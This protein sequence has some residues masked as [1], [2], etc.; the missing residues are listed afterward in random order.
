MKCNTWAR[1][2]G[3]NLIFRRP[4]ASFW[5]VCGLPTNGDLVLLQASRPELPLSQI[6]RLSQRPRE[7]FVLCGW[8]RAMKIRNGL[9]SGVV[10]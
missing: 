9:T 3:K 4:R 5:I 10:L 6:A 1:R 8:R 7:R 2:F